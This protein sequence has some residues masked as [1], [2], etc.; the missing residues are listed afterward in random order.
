[1][2]GPDL[3]GQAHRRPDRRREG[4][5][6]GRRADDLDAGAA[7]AEG[8]RHVVAAGDPVR[9][10]GRAEGAVGGVPRAAR[11]ADPAG[12][13]D[14]RDEPGR[15][16]VPARRRRAARCPTTSRPSCARWSGGSTSASSAGSSSPTPRRRCRG[17]ASRA[18]SC[19]AAATGSRRRTTTTRVP[20]R[21]S[22]T[23]AG[24]APATSRR[25]T[26]SGRIRLVDRTKD[27]I[28]SGGEWI[29]SVELENELMAHPTIREAA[30]I[31]VPAPE[32][33]G[34]SAGVRR[35]RG[36]RDADASR[37]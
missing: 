1:M 33:V 11:P 8:P 13:G 5:G 27:L 15:G 22:P 12:V 37:R 26:R 6:R 10:L 20:A 35:A 18:A 31:G 21:A 16:G 9:R 32:V 17:T 34:A 23:T 7:R 25:W 30:V 24:C 28:K 29:S 36:G 2:P 4:H 3:S 14:D 19:S